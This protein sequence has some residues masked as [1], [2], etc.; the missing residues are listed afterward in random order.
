MKRLKHITQL[1]KGLD[2]LDK[3]KITFFKRNIFCVFV[4][5]VRLRQAEQFLQQVQFLATIG[6]V[7]LTNTQKL[8][9]CSAVL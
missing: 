3:T 4:V 8:W 1:T 6:C 5:Q 7:Q 9:T 2:A